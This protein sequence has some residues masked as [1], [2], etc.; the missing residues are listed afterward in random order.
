MTD[1]LNAIASSWADIF[2][3]TSVQN[4]VFLAVVFGLLWVL[5]R[6]D[7]RLLRV[8]AVIGLVKLLLP[9]FFPIPSGPYSE[10]LPGLSLLF[11]SNLRIPATSWDISLGPSALAGPT[12]G[13]ILPALTFQALLFLGWILICIGIVLLNLRRLLRLRG[14]LSQTEPVG[15]SRYAEI[16]AG[17]VIFLRSDHIHSPLVFGLLRPR[18]ILPRCWETWSHDCKRAVLA[19]EIA[20]IRHGDIW[21]NWLQVMVQAIHFFNPMV[22]LLCRR[23]DLFNE[24]SCDD[25]AVRANR[26]SR[27]HYSKQL[28][29]VAETVSRAV[30]STALVAF[31]KW[32][33]QLRERIA[34][35][36]TGGKRPT[37]SLKR[38]VTTVMILSTALLSF[39]WYWPDEAVALYAGPGN[40]EI[41]AQDRGPSRPIFVDNRTGDDATGNGTEDH[42]FK[43][44]DGALEGSGLDGVIITYGRHATH[45]LSIVP[46]RAELYDHNTLGQPVE[47]FRISNAR[48]DSLA[49]VHP[50]V[51][52]S[53]QSVVDSK[54]EFREIVF[55]LSRTLDSRGNGLSSQEKELG[56]TV[57]F[58][59]P[60]AMPAKI[61][62]ANS[63]GDIVRRYD[64]R[65]FREGPV[66][67]TWDGE[68]DGGIPQPSGTY[69]IAMSGSSVVNDVREVEHVR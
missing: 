3:L 45:R 61:F 35:Q 58:E 56:R 32:P 51:W 9:P 60:E 29:Q 54:I 18:V 41:T 26:F 57:T 53:K 42:P 12:A 49:A 28:L 68:D 50:R 31:L 30:P 2:L 48:L 13:P 14:F 6:S 67:F 59:F 62:V 46:F 43:T 44:V 33:G 1:A 55:H 38:Q 21:I 24:L 4:S 23:M 40:V 27:S 8:I 19:H 20:H 7:V 5:R 69:F 11:G 39:S 66:S 37:V 25:A 10:A 47:M 15:V 22:W 36:L 65:T 64:P 63:F 16:P 17:K 34:Y 52:S